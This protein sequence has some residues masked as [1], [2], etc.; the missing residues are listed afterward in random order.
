VAGNSS[1]RTASTNIIASPGD[2]VTVLAGD[3]RDARFR[4]G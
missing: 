2:G 4:N 1:S 3:G